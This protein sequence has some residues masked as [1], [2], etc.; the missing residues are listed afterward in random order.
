MNDH[1]IKKISSLIYN[2]AKDE[3]D[4]LLTLIDYGL[5]MMP[6]LAFS[7]QCGKE[8]FKN[9]E[10][11]LGSSDYLWEREYTIIKGYGPSDLVFL[12]KDK[13]L[14]NY[15][16]EFKL[17]DTW[18]KYR[19]D[20]NK[21]TDLKD[22]NWVKLFC[23]FKHVFIERDKG[24]NQAEKFLQKLREIFGKNARLVEEARTFKT[25]VKYDHK[26]YF[27]YTFWQIY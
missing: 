10:D 17:D 27:L 22:K 25:K 9:R 16:I 5:K 15:V 20:I 4:E 12:S 3:N 11:I 18:Y 13:N 23:S 26:D 8:I 14:P 21:L 19:N 7:Y 1:V 24:I 2:N 6:E